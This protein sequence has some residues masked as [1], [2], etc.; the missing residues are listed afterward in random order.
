ML[1]NFIATILFT[2]TTNWITVST[3]YPNTSAEPNGFT[4]LVFQPPID[5]Q[6][7]IVKSNIIVII[8]WKG[9]KIETTLESVEIGK[10]KREITQGLNFQLNLNNKEDILNKV[11]A[12]RYQISKKNKELNNTSDTKSSHYHNL[13]YE[14]MNL[15]IIEDALVAS[16]IE[17]SLLVQVGR[18]LN[19][20]N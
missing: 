12:V 20:V 1:T 6:I 3:T 5:N 7:G 11:T 8:E 4:Y 9:Q 13:E 10:Q 15:E 2:I 14:I 18:E 19:K 17:N 16:A